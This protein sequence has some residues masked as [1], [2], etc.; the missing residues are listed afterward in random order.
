MKPVKTQQST[1]QKK[2]SY[3]NENQT[4]QLGKKSCMQIRKSKQKVVSWMFRTMTKK[5]L[6]YL[7]VECLL[8]YCVHSTCMDLH[9]CMCVR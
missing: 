5:S 6:V 1:H 8:L 9:M 2:D 3:I 4:P 7:T